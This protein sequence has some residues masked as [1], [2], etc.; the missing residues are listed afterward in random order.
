[1]KNRRIIIAA[2]LCLAVLI[3]GVG[4]AALTAHI[5]VDGTGSYNMNAAQEGLE[6][7]LVFVDDSAKVIQSGTASSTSVVDT[8]A[9]VKDENNKTSAKFEV[10]TLATLQDEA[11]F[12]Y[13][14]KN[15]NEADV[16]LTIEP[17]HTTGK[18]N[19][20]YADGNFFYFTEVTVY[21][22][23]EDAVAGTNGVN[24]LEEGASY[25]LLAS[26]SVIVRVSVKLTQVPSANTSKP[27]SLWLHISATHQ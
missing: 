8:V 9:I 3:T 1:M 24:L 18:P 16:D 19:P 23:E 7:D 10:N 14:L 21:A 15:N 13:T 5:L 17:L 6:L 20:S 22:T 27:E 26:D 11:I 12:Q 4:Y 25:E 2:F